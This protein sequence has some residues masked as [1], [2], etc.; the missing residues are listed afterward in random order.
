MPEPQSD[1]LI[2]FEVTGDL[3]YKQICPAL[4]ELTRQRLVAEGAG[5]HYRRITAGP[6]ARTPS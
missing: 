3:G 5:R 6:D 2:L 4:H 1:T